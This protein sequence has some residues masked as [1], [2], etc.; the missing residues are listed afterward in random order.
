ML[1]STSMVVPCRIAPST[2]AATSEAVQE[3]SW[4]WMAMLLRS[5]CQ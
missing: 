4:E 3:M 5:T 2:I 1:P